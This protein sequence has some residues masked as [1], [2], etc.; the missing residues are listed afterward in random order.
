MGKAKLKNLILLLLVVTNGLLV[1]L[2][3]PL[4]DQEQSQQEQAGAQLERLFETYGVEYDGEVM[5][6]AQ[7]LYMVELTMDGSDELALAQSILGG[8]MELDPESSQQTQ[9]YV[10]DVGVFTSSRDSSFSVQYT[11][12]PS[13]TQMEAVVADQLRAMGLVGE[14]ASPVRQETGEY[15]VTVTQ[16]LFYVPYFSSQLDFYFKDGVLYQCVGNGILGRT[17]EGGGV[18]SGDTSFTRPDDTVCMGYVDALVAFFASRNDLAWIGSS[19]NQVSQGFLRADMASVTVLRLTPGWKIATDT[20]D[21]WVN[22]ITGVV[23]SIS[24]SDNF[25]ADL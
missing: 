20:G 22:G 1:W 2:A 17:D 12:Q 8:S 14:I 9:I 18:V 21:F 10:S 4:I 15:V 11:A 19:I 16:N 5:P 13:T 24:T 6:E 3:M 25:V 7:T 23:E